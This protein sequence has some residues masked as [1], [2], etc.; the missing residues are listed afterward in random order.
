MKLKELLAEW[1]TRR[2]KS[3]SRY[4]ALEKNK[5]PLTDEERREVFANDAVW[6]YASSIDPISGR[7]VHKISAVWK[8]KN[9]KTGEITYITNTHRAWRH[10]PSIKGA[11]SWY[12]R[13][14]KS[15]A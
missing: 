3:R 14:I 1:Q 10:S 11:I 15:T 7:K 4:Q 12:H 5:I 6:H 13:F 8:S 9:P 2:E